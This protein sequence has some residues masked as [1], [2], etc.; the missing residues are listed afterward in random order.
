MLGWV[1][2]RAQ[3][4]APNDADDYG[5]T[6]QIDQ[7]ADTPAPVFAARAF[8]SAI[9]GTP[10]PAGNDD[11]T[12]Q[13]TLD[14]TGRSQ[15]T[16]MSINNRTPTKPT[17][18]LL[19]PGTGTSRRKKVSFNQEVLQK[20][21]STGSLRKE[22]LTGRKRTPLLEALEN[23]KSKSKKAPIPRSSTISV[24]DSDSTDEWEDEETGDDKHS[25][26]DITLDMAEPRSDSGKYWKREH[27]KYR[28]EALATMEKL[29]KH[30]ELSKSYAKAKD[31]E[32]ME[33]STK[34]D[35]EKSKVEDL[36]RKLADLTAQF[37]GRRPGTSTADDD[38]SAELLKNLAAQTTLAADYKR[39]VNELEALLKDRSTRSSLTLRSS[40]SQLD[41]QRE[42]RRAKSQLR[43]VNELRREIDRLK[44][45]LASSERKIGRLEDDNKRLKS[46]TAGR[47]IDDS[48]VD[49]LKRQL[50]EAR[51]ESRRK[52]DDLRE[53]KKEFEEFR[54]DSHDR[55]ED[56][57]R[58]IDRA[59]DKIAQLQNDIRAL[60]RKSI[61]D[62]SHT[63]MSAAKDRVRSSMPPPSAG[64]TLPVCS[65]N[66]DEKTSP[67][68]TLT[69]NLTRKSGSISANTHNDTATL[70]LPTPAA[71]SDSALPKDDLSP[72][73]R[74]RSWRQSRD[75]VRDDTEISLDF[76]PDAT[77]TDRSSPIRPPAQRA[78]PSSS[79]LHENRPPASEDRSE[80]I[81]FDAV[82]ALPSR[83][84][85]HGRLR[86]KDFEGEREAEKQRDKGRD[87]DRLAADLPSA[88]ASRSA[89][90]PERREAALARIEKRRAEKSRWD[91]RRR[92]DSDR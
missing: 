87:R 43:E 42:L 15:D 69:R 89:L 9:F 29:L 19:T 24:P 12:L 77:A 41:S 84:G 40:G 4:S 33:L 72:L 73:P 91:V 30:K 5:D 13:S 48:R 2:R 64:P 53:V 18:I 35:Q 52:D 78:P 34:L 88:T 38:N 50:R 47:T 44:A 39:Q 71:P 10:T 37:A 6:T 25:Q 58:V 79:R 11:T 46:Q 27:D 21:A 85:H 31:D 81:K 60:K 16:T 14:Y 66:D 54:D 67:I 59:T 65:D 1:M 51:E 45:D 82:P 28:T 49:D 62:V 26:R 56:A 90:P 83:R 74:S 23:S 57:K 8:K 68:R 36:E 7:G 20:N 75:P 55:S 22:T 32:N 70:T 80:K 86:S 3:G 61:P 76:R 92:S 17:G 63:S